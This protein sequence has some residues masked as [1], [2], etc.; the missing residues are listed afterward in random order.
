[1]CLGL[2][3]QLRLKALKITARVHGDEF[4]L[5]PIRGVHAGIFSIRFEDVESDDP[6]CLAH[7]RDWEVALADI[8]YAAGED[9]CSMQPLEGD[10]PLCVT[11]LVGALAVA[12]KCPKMF[13]NGQ[14]L[15][16]VG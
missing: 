10:L 15:T 12:H 7:C 5:G 16:H 11:D 6:H 2:K 3:S 4:N 1:M 9:G 14:L 13:V 8:Q